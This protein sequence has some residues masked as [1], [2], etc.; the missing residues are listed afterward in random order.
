[1]SGWTNALYAVWPAT[2]RRHVEAPDLVEV[3]ESSC[4]PIAVLTSRIGHVVGPARVGFSKCVYLND[5]KLR[6]LMTHEPSAVQIFCHAS[7]PVPVVAADV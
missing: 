6:E 3:V 7:L 5:T 4:V 1:M 2:R